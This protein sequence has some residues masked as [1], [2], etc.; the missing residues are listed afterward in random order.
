[1]VNPRDITGNAEEEEDTCILNLLFS[2]YAT[3]GMMTSVTNFAS[4][5]S[6]NMDRL[7]LDSSHQQRQE[8]TRRQRPQGL[9]SGLQQ[10]LT[11][12]GLSVLGMET[13]QMSDGDG[14]ELI[15]DTDGR[16]DHYA[17]DKC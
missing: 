14:Y 10:G 2:C 13:Q 4:S 17:Y 16:E 8:E 3:P 5:V 15:E 11:G 7:S 9:S 6:R 12:F 1:M